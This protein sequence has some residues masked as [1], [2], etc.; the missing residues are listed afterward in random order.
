MKKG[1]N[2]NEQENFWKGKFGDQ[3]ITRNID[4]NIIAGNINLFSKILNHTNDIKS[5]LELGANVGLNLVAL[6]SLLP[7]SCYT[8]VEINE[9]AYKYLKKYKWIN[10]YNTSIANFNSR[11]KYNFVFTKGVLIHIN[12]NQIKEVYKKLYSLS[13]KYILI[14]EY[15]NPSL[16]TINYRGFENKLFKRDFAGELL[17]IYKDLKLVNYGFSYHLDN[18]FPQDDITWFLL[19]K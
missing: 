10:A 18:N 17:R 14:A 6:K 3:Y 2:L 16:V 1:N 15:Y 9:S 5:V 7:N 4:K 13:D 8:A 11:R 12:P 19:Q